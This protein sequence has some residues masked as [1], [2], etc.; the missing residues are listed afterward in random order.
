MQHNTTVQNRAGRWIAIA[1]ACSNVISAIPLR[2]QAVA[3]AP[4]K[5]ATPGEEAIKMLEFFV[6][7]KGV[8]RA[9]NSITADDAKVALPGATIEKLLSLVPGV[10]INFSD[11]F[12]FKE[13]DNAVRVRS[14]GITALAVTVDDAPMGSNNARYGTPAGRMVDSE[15]LSNIT[16]SPGTG[17]VTTPSFEAL[18]GSIKYYTTNPN[19]TRSVR[20]LQSVGPFDYKRTFVRFDT[21]ELLPG[22]TAFMSTSQL[23]FKTVSVPA[24]SNGSK[25]DTKIN[26]VLPKVR[27]YLAFT[28]NDRDDYDT[29]SSITWDRWRAIETGNP[30]AGYDSSVRYTAAQINNL[31]QFASLGY[32]NYTTGNSSID[33]TLMKDYRDR[34]RQLGQRNTLDSSVNLGDAPNS[35]Y[36]YYARNGRMDGLTRG[37]ADF[38]ITDDLTAKLTA[39]YQH[40]QYYGTAYAARSTPISNIAAAYN[41]ANNTTRELRTDI[42]ARYAYRD[43]GGNL[44]PYGTPGAI[45]VGF[46]DA[47][48]NGYFD[49]GEKLDATKTVT[50]FTQLTTYNAAGAVTANAHALITPTSTTLA[51]AKPAIPGATARDEDFGGFREGVFPKASWVLG[52]HKLTAGIW[53]E[54]DVQHTTRPHYNLFEGSPTGGFLYDQV[55]FNSY[56]RYFLTKSRMVFLEDVSRFFND[57]LTVT[58]GAKSLKVDRSVAGMID[59]TLF[60]KPLSQQYKKQAVTYEDNFLPQAGLT[61]KLSSQIE[62]FTSYARNISAPNQDVI[63]SLALDTGLTP[64]EATNYEFGVRY[65][66]KSFGAT[67]ATFYNAYK[68]RVLTI[69]LSLEE[70]QALGI[71]GFVGTS[72]YR[73]VGGIDSKGAELAWDWRAPIRGLRLN[74]SFAYQKAVF[75]QNLRVSYNSFM[76]NP[77]D[78]RAKFYQIIPNP[79]GGTPTLALELQKGKTQG[80]TPRFTSN[81]DANYTWKQFRVNFGGRYNDDVYVNTLNTEKVPAYFIFRAG[82]TFSGEKGTKWAPFTVSLTSDNVFD[83]YIFYPSAGGSAFDGSVSADYGRTTV[84]SVDLRF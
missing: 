13:S 53:L 18:G 17:D 24:D 25:F 79:S 55:L 69:P 83:R 35:A 54:K 64:E 50:A 39:Y 42:W 46:N 66:T 48:G 26:Y 62:L 2:A 7:E 65:S 29:S 20:I 33:R 71:A 82:F 12:G 74:G 41:P 8:S 22:L 57:R 76:A 78:P 32:V 36:Y 21:G 38:E 67:L 34:G 5:P 31:T 28:W 81:I 45:P 68:E 10:N 1:L 59:A 15:N 37:S 75:E 19:R 61:Y 56:Q 44:V 84:L 58:L 51:D 40:K 60:V 49:P 63:T 70:Q 73:N 47:N 80:N 43:A 77:A 27:F 6:A 11:P 3:P 4:E 30:F 9:T 72:I 23:S 16:V 52:Q 14:F